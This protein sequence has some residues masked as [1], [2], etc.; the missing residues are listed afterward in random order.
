M[1]YTYY[2]VIAKDWTAFILQQ[3]QP[4]TCFPASFQT[5]NLPLFTSPHY[6][7]TFCVVCVC[8][9]KKIWRGP[10]LHSALWFSPH[11]KVTRET[12]LSI[13]GPTQIVFSNS[14]CFPCV[15][16]VQPQILHMAIYVICDVN[17]LFKKCRCSQQI[18]QYPLPRV[19]G[20]LQLEQT[21]CVFPVFWQN[22]KFP[23]LIHIGGYGKYRA[24]DRPA[25]LSSSCPV[26]Q[27]CHPLLPLRHAL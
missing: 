23:E 12:D 27:S 5:M 17:S 22:F 25:S 21:K 7:N 9:D 11:Q 14:L 20:N 18:T 13:Q 1:T 16:P 26:L 4:L 19:S 10:T 2:D 3:K 24:T 15:F 8:L 6:N